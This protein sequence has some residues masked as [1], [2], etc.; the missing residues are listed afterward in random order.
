MAGVPKKKKQVADCAVLVLDYDALKAAVMATALAR[1]LSEHTETQTTT[2]ELKGVALLCATMCSDMVEVT[3]DWKKIRLSQATY[4]SSY[5]AR[6]FA[7]AG[8]GLADLQSQ[9]RLMNEIR[10]KSMTKVENKFEQARAANANFI[11]DAEMGFYA[12]RRVRIT[13]LCTVALLS[14]IGGVAGASAAG[15]SAFGVQIAGFGFVKG[16]LVTI[17]LKGAYNVS[18]SWMKQPTVEAIVINGLE[19][20]KKD[21]KDS[22]TQKT[23]EDSIGKPL[24]ALF[25]KF[26]KS[27]GLEEDALAKLS[28]AQKKF[29]KLAKIASKTKAQEI[30]ARQVNH[31][32]QKQT[33]VVAKNAT[34]ATV[35]KVA[36]GAASFAS[37]A[38]PVLWLCNDLKSIYEEGEADLQML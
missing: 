16:T 17:G 24:T 11:A 32:I 1:A 12:A 27:V 10:D 25:N 21:V 29:E 20:G 22:A 28:H 33:A 36:G 5:L 38:F 8:T 37:K 31:A 7:A 15:S 18:T 23:I 26:A 34:K 2:G 35:A 30:A 3:Q 4:A 14:G 19:S 9:I 6:V 13:A